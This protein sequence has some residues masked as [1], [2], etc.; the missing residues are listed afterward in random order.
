MMPSYPSINAK[1]Y[2]RNLHT[3]IFDEYYYNIALPNLR[4]NSLTV[5]NILY[6]NHFEY[7]TKQ[8]SQL[9]IKVGNI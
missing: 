9:N 7:T 6:Y 8:S 2:N 4:K 5:G 1:I 3:K